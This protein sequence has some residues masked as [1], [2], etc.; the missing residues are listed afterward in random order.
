MSLRSKNDKKF[1]LTIKHVIRLEEKYAAK[2]KAACTEKEFDAIEEEAKRELL[3][4]A[5]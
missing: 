2:I 4:Y 5:V 1:S 3:K